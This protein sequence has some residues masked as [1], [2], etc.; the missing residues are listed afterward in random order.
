[1]I[2]G[3]L[4][5]DAQLLRRD[6]SGPPDEYGNPGWVVVGEPVACELQMQT[7]F[8]DHGAALQS[9]TYRLILAPLAGVRGWDALELDGV[10]YELDGDAWL[11]RNPRTG[12]LSHVEAIVRRVE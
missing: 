12:Q 6:Q 9:S 5:L 1:V 7:S 4:T 3:L 2:G 10:T 8:E 11:A